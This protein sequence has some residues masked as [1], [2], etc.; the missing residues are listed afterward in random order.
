VPA[1][2]AFT[3]TGIRISQG[4]VFSVTATGIASHRPGFT[5][6]PQGVAFNEGTCAKAQSGSTFTA[7][8]LR[9]WSLIG[10]I[11]TSGVIFYVGPSFH[12]EA[13]FAGELFLGF[14]DSYD[15]DNSGA[16]S[17]TISAAR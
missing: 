14:N 3:D 11:G 5:V 13:P 15:R 7:P 8:G 12:L 16:F 4:E 10:R 2:Q 6:G 9:C 17:A 1:T